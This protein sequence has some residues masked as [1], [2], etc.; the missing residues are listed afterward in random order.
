MVTSEIK[1]RHEARFQRFSFFKYREGLT[2]HQIRKINENQYMMIFSTNATRQ[3]PFMHYRV[4][5]F[6]VPTGTISVLVKKGTTKAVKFTDFP[7]GIPNPDRVD[8]VIKR[9]EWK[10]GTKIYG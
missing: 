2:I 1:S 7:A 6:F 8:D 5:R 10:T 9:S 3:V 4:A